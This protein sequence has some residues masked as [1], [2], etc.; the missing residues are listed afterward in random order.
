MKKRSCDGLGPLDYI[1]G[2]LRFRQLFEVVG[3]FPFLL[4]YMPIL[5]IIIIFKKITLIPT[6]VSAPGLLSGRRKGGDVNCCL[7]WTE[8]SRFAFTRS[9]FFPGVRSLSIV[10]NPGQIK[11]PRRVPWFVCLG[12]IV[13]QSAASESIS[14]ILLTFIEVEPEIRYYVASNLKKY[15]PGHCQHCHYTSVLFVNQGKNLTPTL[16]EL[17]LRSSEVAFRHTLYYVKMVFR[18]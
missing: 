6:S 10:N 1:I 5:Q 14:E 13:Q 2:P 12:D 16:W 11:F 8:I 4:L 18:I 15:N 7:H 3:D 17:I 9:L